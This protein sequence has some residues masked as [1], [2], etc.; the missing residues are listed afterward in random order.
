MIDPLDVTNKKLGFRSTSELL[1]DV[2][3]APV[4]AYYSI[5]GSSNTYPVHGLVMLSML[6]NYIGR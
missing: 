5:S 4:D 6:V 3:T 1:C 2:T